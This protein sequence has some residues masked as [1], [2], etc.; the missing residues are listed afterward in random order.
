M[1]L[2]RQQ[3]QQEGGLKGAAQMLLPILKHSFDY[4][5]KTQGQV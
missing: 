5:T 4:E 1:R 3:Q 2:Q